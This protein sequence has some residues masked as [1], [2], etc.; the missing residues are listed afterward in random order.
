MDT[1]LRQENTSKESKLSMTANLPNLQAQ[2]EVADTS[3]HSVHSVWS[4]TST[5]EFH[6]EPFEEFKPLVE[7][8]CLTIWP[9]SMRVPT[10]DYLLGNVFTGFLRRKTSSRTASLFSSNTFHVERL[11]GGSFNRIIGITVTKAKSQDAIRYILRVPRFESARPNQEVAIVEYVHQYSTIPVARVVAMDFTANN[12][13]KRP[14]V[15]Q[16]RI[17]GFDLQSK[18]QNFTQLTHEQQCTFSTEFGRILRKLQEM[19]HSTPGQV[20]IAANQ[21]GSQNYNVRA[22]DVDAD[23]FGD[24]PELDD[25]SL[26]AQAPNHCS[27]LE[28]FLSQFGRWKAAASKHDDSIKADYMKCLAAVATQMNEV[29]FL[30]DNENCLCHLDLN[31]A[32]QNI[33]VN[34]QD[35][36][37]SVSG[38]LDWDSAV[39][40]PRFVG[41]VPPMWIWAWDFEEDEDE[42]HANDTPNSL[43]QQELKQLFEDAVGERFLG[44]A[45]PPQYRIARRLFKF[46]QQGMNASWHIEDADRLISEWA[47]I[48]PSHL[49]E[50]R[51]PFDES[52]SSSDSG[53]DSTES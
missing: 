15:V 46:A 40:A 35:S 17:P 52:D 48:R 25:I 42:A 34:I 12:P 13:L 26:A 28:F 6:H 37:L 2:E 32:P 47:Q 18:K 20:D 9:N 11:S 24:N 38:I 36:S 7:Q 10:L 30:G 43:K 51:N 29:G 45:Y 31:H 1:T 23:P 16:N 22:F 21:D 19:G 49:P 53:D 33:M 4:R 3:K 14:Y 39:F 50:I 41:C 44:F 27:T 5:L 8:L